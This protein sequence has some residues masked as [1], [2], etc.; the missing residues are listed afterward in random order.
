MK[1][2]P[3]FIIT[4]LLILVLAAG[5]IFYWQNK[6]GVSKETAKI[7]MNQK[8][9]LLPEP[10]RKGEVSLEE[11]LQK[12]RSVREYKDETL[13][14]KEISQILW[15][16][17]G[18]TEEDRRTVPSAGALYPIE[19]YL[20][21]RTIE[22]IQKGVYHYIPESHKLILIA[23]GDF[24]KTLAEAALN[25]EWVKNS[26]ANLV[27]TADFQR[28]TQKYEERGIRYVWMEA[29]H[30]AQN[31]YLQATS[32]NLGTVSVGAFEEEKVKEILSL[33]ENI[34]PLYIMPIGK[35]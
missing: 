10:E 34:Q 30:S 23:E 6:K 28:T 3:T 31:V 19:I 13:N 29:G 14:L 15:A 1:I 21:V 33:P 17:Q 2:L 16:S 20:V 18:I 9:I 12:R 8:E 25:Q 32:L 35:K 22:N 7:N 26:A 11:T 4:T 24:S 5:L 27:I